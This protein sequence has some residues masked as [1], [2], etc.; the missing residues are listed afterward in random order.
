MFDERNLDST[1]NG[2]IKTFTYDSNRH[3]D[4]TS[5]EELQ[6]NDFWKGF[7]YNNFPL[8][9]ITAYDNTYTPIELFFQ[10]AKETPKNLQITHVL[11]WSAVDV[12]S[13]S[14]EQANLNELKERLKKATESLSALRDAEV[15]AK[16]KLENVGDA[17]V[18]DLEA[19]LKKAE[20]TL[21][22]NQGELKSLED[23][24]KAKSDAV[25][26]AKDTATDEQRQA[27]TDAEAKLKNHQQGVAD[28]EAE[29]KR[30]QAQIDDVKKEHSKQVKALEKAHQKAVDALTNREDD[31]ATLEGDINEASKLI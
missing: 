19:G 29:V 30:I 14:E 22:T 20:S 28:G 10:T 18:A 8:V 26:Q 25:K 23:D 6:S 2:P 7:P 24:Y 31:I 4:G 16:L 17:H 11:R 3:G 27:M 21:Q 15:Q 5:A 9:R 12:E 1:G 13:V